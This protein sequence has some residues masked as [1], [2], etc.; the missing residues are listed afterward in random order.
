MNKV[1]ISIKE[2]GETIKSHMKFFFQGRK[3]LFEIAF[4]IYFIYIYIYIC[5]YIKIVMVK[6]IQN[7][8]CGSILEIFMYAT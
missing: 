8:Y 2:E 4:Y 1:F 3:K 5:D 7:S 6:R